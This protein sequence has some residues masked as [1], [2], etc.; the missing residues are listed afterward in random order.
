MPTSSQLNSTIPLSRDLYDACLHARGEPSPQEAAID[1][2]LERAEA[3]ERYIDG[4]FAW[5]E[6]QALADLGEYDDGAG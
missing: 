6:R 2:D 5:S 3:W 1:A 4:C